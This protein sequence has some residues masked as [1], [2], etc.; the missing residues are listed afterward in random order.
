VTHRCSTRPREPRT[1]TSC[2]RSSR[3]DREPRRS[4]RRS[5]RP[6]T[7]ATTSGFAR[8]SSFLTHSVF[9]SYHSETEMLRYLKRLE[10]K[11]L[12]LTTSMIALGSCTMKLNATAEMYSGHL[13]G[14]RQDSSVRSGG[15]GER[16]PR[17]VSN[18][19]IP[20]WPRSRGS[21][22]FHSSPNA[23]SQGEYAG[24]LCDPAVSRVA[25][26]YHRTVCLIPQSAHGTNP[27]SAVMAGTES[28]RRQD[29]RQ[30]QHRRLRISRRRRRPTRRI[31][32]R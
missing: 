30:R 26:R 3:P 12:S 19:W 25:R 28:R 31:W 15:A 13:A 21:L 29:G 16:L 2:S 20:R 22:E 24:L 14:V 9:N 17:D 8:T 6:R 5:Q 4:A 10:S 32:L 18:G 11:D 27:A 7:R 1:S 23:G